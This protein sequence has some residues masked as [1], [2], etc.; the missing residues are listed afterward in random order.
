MSRDEIQRP[1]EVSSGLRRAEAFSD[2]ISPL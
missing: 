2:A 1:P